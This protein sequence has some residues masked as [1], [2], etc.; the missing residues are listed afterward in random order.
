MTVNELRTKLKSVPGNW[1]VVAGDV[2]DPDDYP[3][4]TVI[5]DSLNGECDI[6]FDASANWEKE[7][8]V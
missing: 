2:N 4:T 5:K 3:V 1:L 7:G 8:D 6:V